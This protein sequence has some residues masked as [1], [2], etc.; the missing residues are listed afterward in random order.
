M[1]GFP[2][3]VK[4]GSLSELPVQYICGA[5]EIADLCN[6]RAHMD[7]AKY[8]TNFSFMKVDGCGHDLICKCQDS[9][10]VIDAVI[11]QIQSATRLNS[12]N[13]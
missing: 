5:A 13:G 4:I 12:K 3:R 8:I 11:R 9:Q 2:Q 6:D 7:T 1:E 10:K